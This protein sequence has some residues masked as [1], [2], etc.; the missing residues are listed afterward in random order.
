MAGIDQVTVRGDAPKLREFADALKARCV[1]DGV[2]AFVIPV[3]RATY[4]DAIDNGAIAALHNAGF[5]ICDPETPDPAVAKG[6]TAKA[7]PGEETAG[8]I[9]EISG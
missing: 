7:W 9:D 8:L 4:V 3:D 5:T 2:R 1:R 6:E